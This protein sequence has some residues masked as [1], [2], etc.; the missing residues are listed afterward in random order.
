MMGDALDLGMDVTLDEESSSENA[1][2]GA[3]IAC[4]VFE[5]PEMMMMMMM[6]MRRRRRRRM[7]STHKALQQGWL[8]L[9]GVLDCKGL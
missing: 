1:C 5:R 3:R 6:M 8:E 9:N 2:A 4:S 7:I